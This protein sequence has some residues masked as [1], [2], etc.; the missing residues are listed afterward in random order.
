MTLV[1]RF[2]SLLALLLA[3]SAG[4]QAQSDPFPDRTIPARKYQGSMTC[5]S[6][7]V[8]NG[9]IVTDAVVAAYCGDDFRGK[10]FAGEDPGH[11][12]HVYLTIYGD[13][14]SYKQ[15]L[16]FK[17]FT[18][19]KVFT[20]N[21]DPAFVYAF[22]GSVGTT[23]APYIIDITPV[24]L[25]NDADNTAT[26]A[27]WKDQT[28]DIM[29]TGRTLYKDGSWNTIC[30]PFTLT[31]AEVNEHLGNPTGLMTLSSSSFDDTSGTL[32]LNFNNELANG[33]TAGKPY[34]IKWA[35][36]EGTENAEI[37]N[38][39]FTG[40]TISEANVPATSTCTDLIG[41][42]S[43]KTLA[44]NDRT[45][46]YLSDG[47]TLYWPNDDVTVGSCR[48]YFQLNGELKAGEK[49]TEAREFVL[50]FRGGDVAL[51]DAVGDVN[52]DGNITPAD[53][54]MILYYYFDVEQ[55]GFNKAVADVN[56]DNDITPADAIEVLYM[57]FGAGNSNKVARSARPTTGDV[58]DPD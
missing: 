18:Q 41:I 5:T 32:T 51:D 42:T 7:V 10:N 50:N 17:V 29:L 6:Q 58:K 2:Y 15:Y 44:K 46:L 49:T 14:T 21:P 36:A 26:L 54:I 52:S 39:V 11:P 27:A 45:K 31:A 55:T 53:A 3:G 9:E 33:I 43:P 4:L 8:I 13:Y 37:N 23:S 57:Y 16:H 12:S 47:N 19:G 20:C 38:P 30:L 28:C 48:A 22:N 34:I 1:N 56:G 35:K 24:S 25:A 40:V